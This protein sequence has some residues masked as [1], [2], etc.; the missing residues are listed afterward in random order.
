MN[1]TI[2]IDELVKKIT[3]ANNSGYTPL[4]VINGEY[5]NIVFPEDVKEKEDGS[6]KQK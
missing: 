2:H 5:Y 3:A 4:V 6:W 1:Y